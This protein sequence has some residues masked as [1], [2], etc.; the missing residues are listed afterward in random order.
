MSK[1]TLI[2]KKIDKMAW[3]IPIRSLRDKFREKKLKENYLSIKFEKMMIDPNLYFNCIKLHFDKY[4]SHMASYYR[5]NPSLF[6]QDIDKFKEGMDEENLKHLQYFINQI[7]I[8]P[9]DFDIPQSEIFIPIN[10]LKDIF[11]DDQ[12]FFYFNKALLYESFIYEN[13]NADFV[14]PNLMYFQ[15][16]LYYIPTYVKDKLK[17]TICIDCGAYIGD[18]PYIFNKYNFEKIYAFEPLIDN[19]EKMHE[20]LKKVNLDNIVEVCNLCVSD[21]KGSIEIPCKNTG[22]LRLNL[23]SAQNKKEFY[24][25][26]VIT[27]DD[28]FKNRKNKIGLIKAD[29]EGYEENILLG[30]K[31]IILE[32]KP[33]LLLGAYHDWINFGQCFRLKKWIEELNIGYKIIFRQ[34]GCSELLTFCIIAYVE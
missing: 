33:I 26:D 2:E 31:N 15:R 25:V 4:L 22:M 21:Q 5:K 16:G 23:D 32:D 29:V 13:K 30:A 11:S 8:L 9:T 10:I 1:K 28:T 14:N 17:S 18:T 7:K 3:W 20:N 34:I 19:C 24:S 12:I 27:L 6:F